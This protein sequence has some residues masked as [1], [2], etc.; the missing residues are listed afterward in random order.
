MT[1]TRLLGFALALALATW[2]IQ[3]GGWTVIT[4]K[5][6]PTHLMA[7]E[8]TFIYTVRQH[9]DTPMN[10]LAGRLEA[11]KGA[12]LV[13]AM[14][15]PLVATTGRRSAGAYEVNARF[16]EP[17]TWTVTVIAGSG[18][19]GDT[20]T[21]TLEVLPAGDEL[22]VVS[23]VERGR[24]LFAGKGCIMCHAHREFEP[25]LP[26]VRTNLSARRYTPGQVQAFL[27]AVPSLPES[28]DSAGLNTRMPDLG[29]SDDEIGS[30]AAFLG[31][32]PA[33][34]SR[35]LPAATDV[36]GCAHLPATTCRPAG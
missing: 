32:A 23:A 34:D 27:A 16:P 24:A 3:A 10:D 15:R 7:G 20:L 25:P 36:S 17:G 35:R 14:A 26:A 1:N 33:A 12:T 21:M 22:P 18:L 6:V 5:T 29:L 11:R 19:I 8:R 4:L 2:T 28:R 9:G 13:R 30:L 31:Q